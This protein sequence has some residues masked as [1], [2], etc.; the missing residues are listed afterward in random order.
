MKDGMLFVIH[1]IISKRN[2]LPKDKN[3]RTKKQKKRQKFFLFLGNDLNSFKN[4]IG[5]IEN[6]KSIKI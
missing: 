6:N 3:K 5:K 4:L 2:M 1:V